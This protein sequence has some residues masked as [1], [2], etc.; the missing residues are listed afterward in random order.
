MSE[1]LFRNKNLDH[2]SQFLCYW[3]NQGGTGFLFD[4]KLMSISDPFGL[5]GSRGLGA[6]WLS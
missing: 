3:Q 5:N 6:E 2:Q 4:A 1:A